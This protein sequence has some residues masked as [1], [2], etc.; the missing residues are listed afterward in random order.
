MMEVQQRASLQ[1]Q[2][3]QAEGRLQEAEKRLEEASG[4]AS[5]AEE[6]YQICRTALSAAMSGW[7]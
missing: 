2:V 4:Q 7:L 3:E 6:R 5:E 1:A